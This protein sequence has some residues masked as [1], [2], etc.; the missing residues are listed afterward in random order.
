MPLLLFTPSV[1]N[2]VA[3][4]ANERAYKSLSIRDEAKIAKQARAGALGAVQ[5]LGLDNTISI[6]G[7]LFPLWRGR[8]QTIDDLRT[9]LQNFTTF[10]VTTG[11][12]EVKGR[13][14]I[15]SL[16]EDQSDHFDDGQFKQAQW[17]LELTPVGRKIITPVATATPEN[18]SLGGVK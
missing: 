13:Y 2:P 6:D 5:A 14:I 3:F 10:I 15:V 17:H 18:N 16:N 7:A 1:G 11:K 4:D 8:S 9:F 12:G